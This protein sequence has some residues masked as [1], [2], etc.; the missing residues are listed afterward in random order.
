MPQEQLV[1]RGAREHNLK[2]VTVAMPRDRLV[3]ITG[4]SGSGKSSLAFDTI[5]AEGQRR[6]VESLSAY[7]RQF[8]GEMQK[9][10]V[11]QID[12]LSPAI[13]IDQKGAS[14]NPRSTVGTVTEIYDHLRLLFARIGHPHCP[15]CGREIARQSVQQIVDQIYELPEGTRLLVLGPVIKDRKTEGDR[16]FDQIRRQGFARVRVDGEQMDLAETR[17]LDKYKRHTIEV[18]VDRFVVR[19]AEEAA[20]AA[21]AADETAPPEGP[22]GSTSKPPDATRL[23]DSVETALRLGEGVVLIAPS[24]R[25]GEAPDFEERRY[26]E[27]YSCPYDGTTVD[28]LEP[29]SFS[30]NSPHGACPSCTGIG[31]RLEI[32]PDRVIPNKNLS[33]AGGALVPWA[34]LPMENSWHG[35]IIEAVCREHGW[36]YDAP[37]KTLPPE[38]LDYILWS[39]RGEKVVIGYRH[40]RGENTYGA[41]FEGIIPNLERRYR[42]TES[43]FIKSELERYMVARPCPTCVG[44]R[45][46][47]EILAVT[48]DGR[49]IWQVST[50]SITA[51]CDFITALPEKLTEREMAIARQVLKEISSRLGFLLDVGLDYL[52]L[53][54][55][56]Q[57]LS[58]GEAQRI[59]LATQIGSSL[60]GVLY[61]LDE[62]SIGLH[63]RDNAKLIATLTRLRD[64]GNTVLVV[65]H[66]EETIRT[67]DWV[68]DIGP[69]AGE[70][71]GEVVANGPLEAI[72]AEPRSIT[73]AYLRGELR[74]EIPETRRRGSGQSIVIRGAR[75]HNLK[76]LD[77]AFPLARFVAVTGVSGSGKSTLVSDILYRALARELNGARDRAGAHDSIEGLEA[78][79]KVIDIDQSPI[80]RTPRS[81]PAT[82]TGL[83]G[84]IRELFAG[85]QDA[86]VRGYKPGRFSFNV[87]GGRCEHCKGDGILKIEMQFLPDVYVPCEICK[88]KRY[89]R[90]ALE[91]HYKGRSIADVLEM[92]IEE[93]LDFF[94]PVPAVRAKLKTLNDVG[95]GYVHLGQPATTLSGG[96]AQRV[97]LATELSRRATGRTVYVLDEPTTGLHMADVEKLLQVLHRLVDAGNTVV[98]IEHNLDVVKT[99]DWIVD[100]GPEGGERGGYVIA[101]GTPEEVARVPGSATGEYLA[102]VL[103]GEPLVPLS[104]VTFAESAGHVPSAA[105]GTRVRVAPAPGKRA[106]AV[107]LRDAGEG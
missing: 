77:V 44:K 93:A 83:F 69:G 5:Y 37:V 100:L 92:T 17:Q 96:E 30:F 27:R 29:R 6:Y 52:T 91:I 82:Y 63:Q 31:S 34:R 53:D 57:T 58:G 89:N 2:N 12:G 98:V 56:S 74:V 68:I 33:L 66:D 15:T 9:P 95:L 41:T 60:M 39:G 75:E 81:N 85:T 38:A 59:R 106:A 86:R 11:D 45:L 40:E 4:L 48:V 51:T 61:I 42:E 7:A 70:H 22:A 3:V 19:H 65:E 13:S 80:G 25:E 105:V 107:G 21:S 18:V 71:G 104:A 79:D 94:S 46:K 20:N 36:S 87:K 88:G 26:S 35:K 62:P 16:V 97:K 32:D 67:A 54:R 23:A 1:V 103:R 99:A 49:N 14:R 24:P 50:L 84:T 90:E 73:G 55:T 72:L 28:E 64:L 10:D 78:I 8:L 76:N 47:P 102:R 43:D 101:E